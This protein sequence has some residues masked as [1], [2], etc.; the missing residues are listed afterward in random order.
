MP[1]ACGCASCPNHA[2][3]I[4]LSSRAEWSVWG[5]QPASRLS[6]KQRS[7]SHLVCC[8]VRHLA[9]SH[10]F[11]LDVTSWSPPS[12]TSARSLIC[13]PPRFSLRLSCWGSLLWRLGL[14]SW[15][16]KSDR[17]G[18]VHRWNHLHHQGGPKSCSGFASLSLSCQWGTLKNWLGT[19]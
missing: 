10:S 5:A 9:A 16:W 18:S 17:Q 7:F 11:R 15:S 19:Y 2:C 1:S 13:W 3:R 14:H 8:S 4:A 12:T 6:R